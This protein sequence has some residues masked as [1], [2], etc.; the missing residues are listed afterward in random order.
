MLIVL[1]T[2]SLAHPTSLKKRTRH[3][4]TLDG[5]GA[6]EERSSEGQENAPEAIE[7]W[8]ILS[9]LGEEVLLEPESCQA[10]CSPRPVTKCYLLTY[11]IF[12]RSLNKTSAYY[13]PE[14][15]FQCPVC[16]AA[17]PNP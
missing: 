13:R 14:S 16:K 17:L 8:Q 11:C 15:T 4:L 5:Y 2:A 1:G 3:I 12:N 10:T 6:P 9:V 7:R